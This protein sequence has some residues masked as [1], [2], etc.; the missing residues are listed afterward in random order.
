MNTTNKKYR[1]ATTTQEPIQCEV[2][3]H[4][5]DEHTM[6][7]A[8][9][10]YQH[11]TNENIRWVKAEVD[12]HCEQ[13]DQLLMENVT[14][15]TD[16]RKYNNMAPKFG[17][18]KDVPYTEIDELKQLE[19]YFE[20]HVFMNHKIA[21]LDRINEI[22]DEHY[23]VTEQL[24]IVPTTPQETYRP[25]PTRITDNDELEYVELDEGQKKRMMEDLKKHEVPPKDEIDEFF[26]ETK[27]LSYLDE[28]W[29]RYLDALPT[30]TCPPNLSPK[31]NKKLRQQL[32][33]DVY[34]E[35]LELLQQVSQ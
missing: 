18:S 10:I 12:L 16:W 14:I 35:L 2:C 28:V 7:I 20:T 4:K 30:E 21:V 6:K 13:C 29:Q 11:P 31:L 26:E 19:W 22:L 34:N 15:E 33:V 25:V 8:Y 9:N 32:T 24:K 1:R 27:E 23:E 3:D 17:Y 5:S